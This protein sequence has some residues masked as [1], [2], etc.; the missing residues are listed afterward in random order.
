MC[1]YFTSKLTIVKYYIFIEIF[2]YPQIEKVFTILRLLVR[3]IESWLK[4]CRLKAFYVNLANKNRRDGM[5]NVFQLAGLG[6]FKPNVLLVGFK[7]DW[8]I[9]D[10]TQVDEINNYVGILR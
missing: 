6:K 7:S 9:L 8:K 4:K 1:T 10:I 2:Q 3:E 5:Q